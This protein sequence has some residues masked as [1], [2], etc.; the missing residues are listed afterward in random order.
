[1]P[2]HKSLQCRRSLLLFGGCAPRW[3]TSNRSEVSWVWFVCHKLRPL[4]QLYNHYKSPWFGV[5]LEINV[6]L[7]FLCPFLQQSDQL[8][9]LVVQLRALSLRQLKEVWQEASFK[10]RDDWSATSIKAKSIFHVVKVTHFLT[11]WS[12]SQYWSQR[13]WFLC[14]ICVNTVREH[15]KSHS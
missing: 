7:S 6:N 4:L 12:D 11:M 1:M 15:C 3:L 10:C 2:K 5:L 9:N 13:G 8:L 14:H